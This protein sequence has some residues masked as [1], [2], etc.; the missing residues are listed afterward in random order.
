MQ[1]STPNH[2]RPPG[3][4]VCHAKGFRLFKQTS[5]W[6]GQVL[7]GTKSLLLNVNWEI[8]LDTMDHFL[9][10]WSRAARPTFLQAELGNPHTMISLQAGY[11]SR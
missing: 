6:S 4:Q 10:R 2:P 5:A 8:Q 3:S 11:L 9:I 1:F 7:P